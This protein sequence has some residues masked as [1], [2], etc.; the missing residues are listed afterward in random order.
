MQ[1]DNRGRFLPGNQMA[2]GNKGNTKPKTG[3]RNAVKHGFFEK[4]PVTKLR[5]DGTL[6]ISNGVSAFT[7]KEEGFY[8]DDG[9]IWIRDDIAA[10]LEQ[11]G[12]SLYS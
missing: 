4:L 12:Y 9:L 5:D 2:K 1:R 6:Y 11:N 10:V 7:I 8:I 3:N